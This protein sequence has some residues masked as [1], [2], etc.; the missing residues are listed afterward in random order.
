MMPFRAIPAFLALGMA[1]AACQS[2]EK[3]AVT[4][5]AKVVQIPA[6]FALRRPRWKKLWT[7]L[8]I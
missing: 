1:L 2:V 3:K 8:M 6:S 4:D 5:Q 7:K